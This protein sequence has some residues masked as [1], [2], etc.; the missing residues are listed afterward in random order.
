MSTYP[1]V[2]LRLTIFFLPTFFTTLFV[3]PHIV[4][5][6]LTTKKSTHIFSRVD[7]FR[8]YNYDLILM[9]EVPVVFAA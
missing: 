4:L 1:N 6:F 5:I 2:V 7:F 8:C 3:S 9:V